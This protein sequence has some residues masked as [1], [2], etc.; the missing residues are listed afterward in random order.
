MQSL[1]SRFKQ[2]LLLLLS[3][4]FIG[5]DAVKEKTIAS[6]PEAAPSQTADTITNDRY[7]KLK[8][9]LQ[10]ADTI[11]LVNYERIY[12]PV[13]DAK[14]GSHREAKELIEKGV[15]N[16]DIIKKTVLLEGKEKEAL[17]IILTQAVKGEKIELAHCFDPHHA[18]IVIS[19]KDISYIECCFTCGGVSTDK[20]EI[21]SE[22]F[23]NEKWDKLY[24]YI[25]SK[26]PNVK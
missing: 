11:L 10:G 7:K 3:A 20:L 26:I 21:S 5:C 17:I 9:Q 12:V 6:N 15:I 14:N 16:K 2:I 19:K 4:Y 24:T 23:D 18:F 1:T 13:Y 22:D 25:N 8:Q